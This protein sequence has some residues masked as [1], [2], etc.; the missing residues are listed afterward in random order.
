MR[1]TP[2]AS[3]F[4]ILEDN[5]RS[6]YRVFRTERSGG[7]LG[8]APRHGEN[9][10]AM[11]PRCHGDHD[12]AS[13][14][15]SAARRGAR[16]TSYREP[17]RFFAKG[18]CKRKTVNIERR[19]ETNSSPA[20]RST[21]VGARPGGHFH[22]PVLLAAQ[23]AAEHATVVSSSSGPTSPACGLSEKPTV[24]ASPRKFLERSALAKARGPDLSAPSRKS[25]GQLHKARA[26]GTSMGLGEVIRATCA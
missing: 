24:P 14:F 2:Q 21:F 8:I 3:S 1:R 26:L 11:I 22:F 15:G 17:W 5:L 6:C 20:G 7:V 18:V 25:S 10:Q 12:A 13:G 16:C 9:H 23:D 4:L 19:S